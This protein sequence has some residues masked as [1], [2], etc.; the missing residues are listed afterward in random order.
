MPP[1]MNY[2]N[3]QYETNASANATMQPSSSGNN[4]LF[5]QQ[6]AEKR[7]PSTIDNFYQKTSKA[8][9]VAPKNGNS[10]MFKPLPLQSNSPASTALKI[11]LANVPVH[12]E[13]PKPAGMKIVTGTIDRII[14]T[15]KQNPDLDALFEVF[16]KYAEGYPLFFVSHLHF[17]FTFYFAGANVLSIRNTGSIE[18]LLIVRNNTGPV[19]QAV[20][21]EIDYG[22]PDI[23]VGNSLR[24]IGRMVG[25][26]RMQV[27]KISKLTASQ[28]K[29]AT[30][31]ETISSFI[32]DNDRESRL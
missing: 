29:L 30:R 11:T 1:P 27:M 17:L 18:K 12:K 26:N 6:S 23:V 3:N 7:P 21:Y 22:L 15:F 9:A 10:P 28:T 24:I 8:R 32:V 4:A 13:P 20:Y 16:G 14:R 31:L 19:M 25:I 5:V 2:F